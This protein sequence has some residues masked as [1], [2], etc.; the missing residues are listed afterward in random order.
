MSRSSGLHVIEETHG[1]SRLMNPLRLRIL[2]GVGDGDSAAGVARRLALPR[3]KVNY[4]LRELER[5]GLVELAEER[6]KGNCTERIVRR[7]ADC[8]LVNPALLGTLAADPDRIPDRLSAAHVVAVAARTIQE[9]AALRIGAERAG[10]KL[11]TLS[12]QAEVRFATPDAR[13][14]FAEELTDSIARLVAKHH[15][16]HAAGG[17]AFRVTLAAYPRVTPRPGAPRP[18]RKGKP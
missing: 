1:A 14:A 15:D 13:R 16:E 3:Q 9:I 17:R 7:R 11:A 12:I 8:Y 10:K 5:A 2:E 18:R 6:R 4:H